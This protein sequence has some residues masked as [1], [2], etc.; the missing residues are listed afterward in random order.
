[1]A[2]VN[3]FDMQGNLLG[4][5]ELK[6]EI[7]GVE[8]NEALVHQAVVRHLANRRAG[9]ADTKTRAEVSGGGRKPW[10]QKGTGRARHGSTRSPI[11]KHGGVV[12]GPHPRSYEQG[13][14]KK[15]RKLALKVVLSD[16]VRQS[17]LL[18]MDRLAMEGFKTKQFVGIHTA[19]KLGGESSLYV[20]GEPQQQV[21]KSAS[22]VPFAKVVTWSELN[23][24]D[25]LKYKQVVLTEDAI[26][27]IE[28]AFK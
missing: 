6:D 20:L 3:K 11:W 19:L 5:L 13:L 7:F 17:K 24:F 14:N 16:K 12:W 18:A 22:N 15:M 1:M 2:T 27:K 4:S 23:V 26:A 9:T 21:Q 28:E 25:L 8:S 10:R